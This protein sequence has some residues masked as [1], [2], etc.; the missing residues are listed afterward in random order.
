MSHDVLSRHMMSIYTIVCIQFLFV[1]FPLL[2]YEFFVLSKTECKR[3]YYH[4]RREYDSSSFRKLARNLSRHLC[5]FL[6][7][8][9]LLAINSIHPPSCK[10][11]KVYTMSDLFTVIKHHWL[12]DMYQGLLA[13][14]YKPL[15]LWWDFSNVFW[16]K[17]RTQRYKYF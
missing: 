9:T 13:G 17:L 7:Q 10:S 4:F 3:I 6:D 8:F 1:Q 15:H 14:L 16:R 11:K 12:L 2:C 5:F